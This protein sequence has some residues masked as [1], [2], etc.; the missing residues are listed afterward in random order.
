MPANPFSSR[1]GRSLDKSPLCYGAST[2]VSCLLLLLLHPNHTQYIRPFRGISWFNAMHRRP[3]LEM[4][5]PTSHC[6]FASS[7]FANHDSRLSK[8]RN[9]LVDLVPG[10]TQHTGRLHFQVSRCSIRHVLAGKQMRRE[11]STQRIG[12]MK[13]RKTQHRTVHWTSNAS[14]RNPKDCR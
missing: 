10:A 7:F 14:T 3:R 6:G 2:S 13:D 8:L 9:P 4:H 11:H 5:L 12:H 1:S